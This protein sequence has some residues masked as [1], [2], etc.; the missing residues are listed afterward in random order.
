M[1]RILDGR[2]RAYLSLVAVVFI[3]LALV[4]W[5]WFFVALSGAVVFVVCSATALWLRPKDPAAELPSASVQS[6]VTREASLRTST[7]ATI[8]KNLGSP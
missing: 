3:T 7:E 6:D 5:T 4:S 1:T 8:T 2:K